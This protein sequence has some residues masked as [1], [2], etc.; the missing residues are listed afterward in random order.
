MQAGL[1]QYED[2]NSP[3]ELL[4]PP[5]DAGRAPAC[6]GPPF[7]F[8]VTTIGHLLDGRRDAAAILVAAASRLCAPAAHDQPISA[9]PGLAM[10]NSSPGNIS[11]AAEP[12]ELATSFQHWR[13]SAASRRR[14]RELAASFRPRRLS[15]ATHASSEPMSE[16]QVTHTSTWAERDA[17]LRASAISL[18][19][20][21]SPTKEEPPSVLPFNTAADLPPDLATCK[22]RAA[23]CNILQSRVDR[24][25]GRWRRRILYS[26]SNWAEW[27]EWSKPSAN[28]RD[29]IEAGR[30]FLEPASIL[31]APHLRSPHTETAADAWNIYRRHLFILIR[32]A[33]TV[34]FP[35]TE[36]LTRLVTTF[37]DPSNG[38]PRL[39][40]HFTA[41]LECPSL[42]AYP[43]LHADV[44]MYKL[45]CSYAAGS[46]KYSH[47]ST[48]VDWE[49]AVSRLPGEDPV[50]LAIRVT[51]AFLM[52]HDDAALTDVT[53]WTK[54]SF[55]SEINNRYA[56][57]LAADTAD[58]QRG[59]E[60]SHEFLTAW[61]RT[62][63]LHES[64]RHLTQPFHLSCEYLAK[65]VIVPFESAHYN[66]S[67]AAADDSHPPPQPQLRLQ[68]ATGQGSRA[69]RDARR[70]HLQHMSDGLPP[71]AFQNDT[72]PSQH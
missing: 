37:S 64:D 72:L 30:V 27:A 2:I 24:T 68:H 1:P 17:A 66:G 69:R 29:R 41:A 44:L 63:A 56:A 49:S 8:V 7:D 58:P 25:L 36:I 43:L 28:H 47:D 67:D 21:A 20:S 26:D 65:T 59:A 5:P 13:D 42:L 34:G 4:T 23:I 48:T 54:P 51:N 60:S 61:N 33:L 19:T 32:Q 55:V 53:V 22:D 9:V 38:Y 10:S 15:C 14:L 39:V 6:E 46:D 71:H 50:S 70:A 62:Q 52:K 31:T 40:N 35:W 3:A 18:P 16:P 12:S 45:D 11:W 57:C